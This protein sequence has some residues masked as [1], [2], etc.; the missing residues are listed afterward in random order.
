LSVQKGFELSMEDVSER[1]E[2]RRMQREQ[3]RERRRMRD[4]ERRQSMTLEQRE[5]H[6]ARRRRNYQL[7]RIRAESARSGSQTG[8]T[9]MVTGGETITGDDHPAVTSVSGLRVKCNGVTHV[10]I[11]QGEEKLD[12]ECLESEG[13]C[14][15]TLSIWLVLR[16]IYIRTLLLRENDY[17][18]TILFQLLL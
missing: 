7:R 17:V 1:S 15:Y 14:L 8:Q 18:L 4:R 16:K 3:E 5:K 11:N 2:L 13:K 9:S 10:G 6:L 12:V